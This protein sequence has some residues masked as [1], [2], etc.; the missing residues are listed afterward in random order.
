[1]EVPNHKID[2]AMKI[3][4]RYVS[5]DAPLAADE[6]HAVDAARHGVGDPHDV[7]RAEAAQRN[8][9]HP[10]VPL[11]A[12]C[13]GSDGGGSPTVVAPANVAGSWTLDAEN[14]GEAKFT[15]C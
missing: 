2:T 1:M 5:M 10:R 11:L 7:G 4:T 9:P 6:D 14:A 3:A 12:G 13:G 8:H 15:G